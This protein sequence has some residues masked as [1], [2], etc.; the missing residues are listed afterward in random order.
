MRAPMTLASL[1]RLADR[2]AMAEI[3]SNFKKE[4]AY[5]CMRGANA[6]VNLRVGTRSPKRFFVVV[7]LLDKTIRTR[8][9]NYNLLPILFPVPLQI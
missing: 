1:R 3:E 9:G 6:Y 4:P 7:F 5:K 2:S 8:Q